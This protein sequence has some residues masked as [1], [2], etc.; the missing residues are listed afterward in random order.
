M[1]FEGSNGGRHVGR[2]MYGGDA[3]SEHM[4]LTR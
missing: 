3:S 4:S 2:V 1:S